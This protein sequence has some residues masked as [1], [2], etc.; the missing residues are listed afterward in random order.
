MDTLT[1]FKNNLL[2]RGLSPGTANI[3]NPGTCAGSSLG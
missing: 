3:Y 1:R 2:V